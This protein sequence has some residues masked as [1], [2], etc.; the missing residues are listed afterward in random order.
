MNRENYRLLSLAGTVTFPATFPNLGQLEIVSEVVPCSTQPGGQ[1]LAEMIVV[2]EANSP[3][4][5]LARSIVASAVKAV[6]LPRNP[7]AVNF[8]E[9]E[10]LLG[11]EVLVG[12]RLRIVQGAAP[13]LGIVYVAEHEPTLLEMRAGMTAAESAQYYPPLPTDR[14]RN[15]YD[16]GFS[17]A[18]GATFT[19]SQGQACAVETHATGATEFPVRAAFG[20]GLRACDAASCDIADPTLP[21]IR[22]SLFSGL[23]GHCGPNDPIPCDSSPGSPLAPFPF[24]PDLL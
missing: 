24:P 10:W 4:V 12:L 14:G 15:H 9:G 8:S 7:R 22:L 20:S 5:T 19:V 11:D 3:R 18:P 2:R 13:V 16:A 1:R 17:S 21:S 23:S 6:F